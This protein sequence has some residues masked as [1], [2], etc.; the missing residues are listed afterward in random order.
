MMEITLEGV[1]GRRF[2]RKHR[3]AVRNPNEAIR[4]LCQLIPGFRSFLTSAHE[5]GIYFQ[6]LTNHSEEG[7]SYDDLGLGCNSMILVPVITGAAFSFQNILTILVGVALVAFS[8]GAFGVAFGAAGT[9]SA[10]FQTAAMSL[11]FALIFTGIAGLFA[12]GTPQEGKSEGAAANDAVFGGAAG[13]ASA[14]TPIPL[15]YG[16]F[17]AQ[18]MPV[19]SSYI[20]DNDGYLMTI[21]SEGTI[22]GLPNGS[23]KDLYFNGLQ[24][25][26][27][28]VSSV[29]ITDGSQTNQQITIVKSA[30]FHLP[31]ST[32]LNVG[33]KSIPNAQ[34]IRS[35]VQQYADVLKLRIV[36]GPCYSIRTK[37]PKSGGGTTVTYHKY[38]DTWDGNKA[39]NPIEYNVQVTDGDGV[40]FYNQNFEEPYLKASEIKI[41]E[42]NIENRPI[43]VSV[44]VTRLDR[45]RAPDP[46]SEEGGANIYNYQWVKG[47]VQV[48]SLDVMWAERLVYPSTALM[49][50]KF[51]AGEF[52]QM[53]TVQGLFKGIKVPQ[54]TSSLQVFYAWSDNPAYVLLDLITNPRYGLGARSFTLSGPGDTQFVQPGIR[55]EDVDLASFRAAARFCED[56][57]YKFNAY[58]DR[59]ADA[60]DLIR[61]VASSFNAMLVYAGGYITLVLDKQ[62]NVD[63]D[64]ADLRLF[65]EAN[66]LQEVDDGGEVQTPCFSYEGTGRQARSTAVQVSYVNANEFYTED[67]IVIEDTAAIERYGYNLV[68]IRALGCTDRTQAERVGRYTLGSNLHSTETVTF[69]VASEGAMLLPGDICLIADPLKTRIAC[70]GRIKTASSSLIIADRDLSQVTGSELYLY[71]YGQSGLCQRNAISAISGSQVSISGTF[72]ST[73]SSSQMWVIVDEANENKFRRYR[74]QSVKENANNT[75]EVVGLLYSDKKFDIV[76]GGTYVPMSSTTSFYQSR[77]PAINPSKIT[78]SLRDA[79][80]P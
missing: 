1:A 40:V 52:Q 36:R 61:A 67:K 12:P 63:T 32:T 10:G 9:I 62:F 30:G 77:N 59:N 80:N 3:L 7:I 23:S 48:V 37:S 8:L 4:A 43:P 21:I 73:P 19:I 13:T 34:I 46:E 35:F 53:P 16:T 33:L 74:V 45:G 25:A 6:M 28:S 71:T 54:L 72:T 18:S 11:G 79:T 44:S 49:A 14:G 17:L 31:I 15:L 38:T 41:I 27:S 76:N 26:S 55:I 68:R 57:G 39:T 58:I 75:Y 66:V 64:V 50:M 65:S 60:L 24:S 56:N 20:D 47:D 2:G 5:Y 69:K 42:V 78:F 51:S 70:G 29:Q 22:E